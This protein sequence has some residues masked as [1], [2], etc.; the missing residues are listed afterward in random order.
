VVGNCRG[1]T[2]EAWLSDEALQVAKRA[3][4]D[5]CLNEPFAGGHVI[6]RHARPE[7]GVQ[8]LQ[9]EIDRRYYLDSSMRGPGEGFER[10]AR[11]IEAL[12][13][14]LGEALLG[15]RFATAAE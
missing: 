10:A 9:L 13:V 12:A 4:F 6:E 15:S 14:E 8:A 7:R 11:L 5:A 3:G 1:R 2:A